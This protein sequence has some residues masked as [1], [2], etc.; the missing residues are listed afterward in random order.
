[1]SIVSSAA[2]VVDSSVLAAAR[3]QAPPVDAAYADLV[4]ADRAALLARQAA[5]A[6]SS[7]AGSSGSS[8]S[9]ESGEQYVPGQVVNGWLASVSSSGQPCWLPA[10]PEHIAAHAL[11]AQQAADAE[12]VAEAIAKKQSK[13]S[14]AAAAAAASSVGGAPP[15]QPKDK[16]HLR[17]AAGRVWD[18]P[19]LEDW[20]EST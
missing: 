3:A 5:S 8:G 15:A 12:A 14:K 2:A 6:A 11:R 13:A 18:D 9:V 1:V 17:T 16:H 20:P 4:A 19:T 7:V 10:T